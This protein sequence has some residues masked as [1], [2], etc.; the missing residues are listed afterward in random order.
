[1]MVIIVLAFVFLT[2]V[3][4]LAGSRLDMSIRMADGVSFF[5]VDL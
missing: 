5:N 2:S 1:M 4:Q 3:K